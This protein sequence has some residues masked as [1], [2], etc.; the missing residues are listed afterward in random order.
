VLASSIDHKAATAAATNPPELRQVDFMT[1]NFAILSR[2][3]PE[4]A[5]HIE[6]AA[7]NLPPFSL[8][9]KSDRTLFID[10]IHLTSGYDRQSEARLQASLIPDG[11]PCAHVY[12]MA[13]GDLPRVLLERSSI[14]ELTVVVMNCAIAALSLYFFDHRDWLDDPRLTLIAAAPTNRLNKPFATAPGCL[15]L[16][17]D[18]ASRLRDLVCLELATPFIRKRH[19]ADNPHL[20][21]RLADNAASVAGDPP[22]EE[23]A[24]SLRGRTVVVAAAGPSLSDHYFWMKDHKPGPIIAVDA[25]LKPLMQ[26]GI[27][28]DVVVTIDGHADVY[29][30]FFADVD[31]TLLRDSAL[32]YF[33]VV[34]CQTLRHW[35]GRRFAAWSNAPIY[36]DLAKRHPRPVLFSSGSVI[37]PAVDLATR[38]SREN[39]ILTGA[40]FGYPN[41]RSHVSGCAQAKSV[42]GSHWVLNSHGERI[43]TIPSLRAYLRDLES[44]MAGKKELRFFNAGPK[45]AA[46]LHTSL[47]TELP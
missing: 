35:P 7:G 10:G 26:A 9:E 34:Q 40:D 38:L 14:Q 6:K 21:K 22:V 1:A 3:W 28:P 16:A 19:A 32:V 43:A 13:L 24:S 25:A 18:Q 47:L 36:A 8:V 20:Q 37:H 30:L 29:D 15:Q 11:S 33:P 44:F 45:G 23:L 12:G 41:G 17:S 42:T 46:I 39:I 5:L 4:L 31:L 2:R 27:V